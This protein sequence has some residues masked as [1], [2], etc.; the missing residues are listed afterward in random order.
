M[1]LTSRNYMRAI[2]IYEKCIVSLLELSYL[3][4][5]SPLVL[6]NVLINPESR[7][8]NLHQTL[9]AGDKRVSGVFQQHDGSFELDF[10]AAD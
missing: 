8:H 9:W 3:G 6:L 1:L 4:Q 10:A 5:P 2:E 7:H